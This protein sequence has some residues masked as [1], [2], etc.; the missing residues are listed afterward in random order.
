MEFIR[1][2]WFSK[3]ILGK[4]TLNWVN[5]I[6]SRLEGQIKIELPPA[7]NVWFWNKAI[8]ERDYRTLL[9]CGQKPE[10]A[11]EVLPNSLKTE[12]VVKASIK[13]WHHIFSLRCAKAAHPQIRAL[14][15]GLWD[16]F[17]TEEP[18][19]F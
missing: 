1:P 18:E 9:D 4:H 19:L 3:R 17:Q 16:E 8:A 12:I 2:V 10:Q 5:L 7:E 15:C 6:C 11:R 13:E 14:M